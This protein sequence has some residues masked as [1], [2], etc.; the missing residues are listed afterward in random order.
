MR[1]QG[2]ESGKICAHVWSAPGVVRSARPAV[3]DAARLYVGGMD[4]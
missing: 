3:A 1:G 4:E 2:K